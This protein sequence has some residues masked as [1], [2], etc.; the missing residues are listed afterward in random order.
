MRRGDRHGLFRQEPLPGAE[1]RGHIFVDERERVSFEGIQRDIRKGIPGDQG[2]FIEEQA[3]GAGGVPRGVQQGGLDSP[4]PEDRRLGLFEND[5]VRSAFQGW[6]GGLQIRL[7][8]KVLDLL[9][10]VNGRLISSGAERLFFVGVKDQPD[11]WV[12]FEQRGGH[13]GMVRVMMGEDKRGD[14]RR[15]EAQSIQTTPKALP[16]SERNG[17]DQDRSTV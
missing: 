6:K 13:S 14:P 16:V 9:I 11:H 5:V 10:R 12:N 7:L 8:G 17:I 15:R 1:Q 3:N 2:A 4:I